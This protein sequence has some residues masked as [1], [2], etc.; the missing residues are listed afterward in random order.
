MNYT[1]KIQ[2]AIKFAIKTHEVYQKQIRKGKEIAYIT[3]PLTVGIILANASA[4]EDV[5]VAGILHDTIEDSVQEKKVTKEMISKRFG[6]NVMQ[7]V[8]SVTEQNREFSWEERKKE[9]LEHIKDFNNDSL[10]V[11]SADVVSNVS[12]LIDDYKRDGEQV[13]LRFHASK[14]KTI[15]QQLKVINAILKRWD[16]NPLTGNLVFLA[17]NLLEIRETEVVPEN[18]VKVMEYQDYDENIKIQCPLCNWRG[19]PKNGADIESHEILFDVYCPV[20]GKMLLI[21]NSP[22]TK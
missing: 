10:L 4:N 11:K 19:T 13:F 7:L 21:V 6:E 9:A 8:L 5:I 20:C 1:T 17:K 3:H 2:R 22:S 15:K 16:E 14:E 12:E 18:R